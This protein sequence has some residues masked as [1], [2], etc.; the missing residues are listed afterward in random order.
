METGDTEMLKATKEVQAVLEAGRGVPF[1]AKE[2]VKAFGAISAN[3]AHA[4]DAMIKL[5]AI[6]LDCGRVVLPA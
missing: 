6:P 3:H 4:S 1:F 5:M 2:A